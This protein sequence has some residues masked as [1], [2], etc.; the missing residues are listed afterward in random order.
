MDRFEILNRMEEILNEKVRSIIPG[1]INCYLIEAPVSKIH[2]EAVDVHI[3]AHGLI[4][5]DYLGGVARMYRVEQFFMFH[6]DQSSEKFITTPEMWERFDRIAQ[7]ETE[8]ML[9]K[10]TKI[11]K[12]HIEEEEK[13]KRQQLANRVIRRDP[14]WPD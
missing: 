6:Y 9:L 11:I 12:E 10:L 4:W 2:R 14:E 13:W 5:N 7:R 3:T 1:M 8:E